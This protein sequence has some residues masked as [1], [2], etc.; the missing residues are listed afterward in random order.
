M[1]YNMYIYIYIYCSMYIYIYIYI[2]MWLLPTGAL[3]LRRGLQDG[4]RERGLL[5]ALLLYYYGY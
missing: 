1:Y 2:C 5:I 4:L 3:D